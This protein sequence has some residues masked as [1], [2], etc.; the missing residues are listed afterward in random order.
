DAVLE[1]AKRANIQLDQIAL[2]IP[3]QAN[4]RIIQAI[5]ERLGV[6]SDKLFVNLD[7][8]GN[9]SAASVGIALDEAVKTGKIKDGQY[10]AFVA[11]GAGTTLAS[12]IVKW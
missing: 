4:D 5:G 9:T 2:V 3:H 7:K 8:I 11:F 1:A 12:S 6:S 10:V